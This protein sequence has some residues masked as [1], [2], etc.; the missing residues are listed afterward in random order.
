LL[1]VG[2]VGSVAALA[3]VMIT[4]A[5]AVH[6]LQFQL[7]GDTTTVCGTVPNCSTQVYDWNSLFNADGTNTS[8]INPVGP[9]FTTA[10]FVRDF[11]V[12][13]AS[14]ACSLTDTTSKTFCTGDSTTYAT[15]SKD[16]LNITPGWQCKHDNNVNSKI[17]I[18][19][20]YSAAYTDPASGDKILYFGLDKN[21]DNGNN[22]VGFWFLQGSAN[23]VAASGEKGWTG[24]HQDG[25]VLVVSE[26]TSGGGVSS[27][28]AY[29][30]AGGAS[31]CIDSNDNPNAKTGGCNGQAIENGGDCKEAGTKDAICATTNSGTLAFNG[32]IT[33]KWLTSDATLGVGHTVVPPDFFEGGVNLTKVFNKAGGTVPQ[34]FNTFIGD[35]RSSQSLT[36][37][38]FDYTRGV[39]GECKTTLATQAGAT[40]NGGSA[41][42]SSIGT[43]KVSSG[44]DTATLTVTGTK[45]WGG[46]LTWH[47]CGPVLTDG[48]ESTKGVQVTSRTVSNESAASAFVSGTAQLTSVGR[49]CWTAH[50]Q[51]NAES[52]AAGVKAAD[53]NGANECFTVAPVTPTLTTSASCSASPCVLGSTLSDKAFLKGTAKQPGTN[54]GNSNYPSINATNG[55]PAD[56]SISWVLYSPKSG[57]CSVTKP[58][59]PSSVIVSGDN[60]TTGYGPTSYTTQ[61]SDG[62]GTY[63]FV[64]SYPGDGAGSNTNAAT[65]TS[66][67]DTSGTETVIVEGTS[68]ISSAQRWLPNDRVVV[69]GQANLNGG[70]TVTLYPGGKCEGTPITGQSY[71]TTF[72]EATSPQVFNTS[73]T[74]FFVGTKPDGSAGG[75]AG[76]YSWKVHYK[77]NNLQSPT[78][79]CEKSNVSITN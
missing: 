68:S 20:A 78:D 44:S 71:T 3:A 29:R 34:C 40:A 53:D 54:G 39:L 59:S 17:D 9:G 11:G 32:N 7:D 66:C 42:P 50:F 36:A 70:L 1:L 60:T 10:S 23:C 67:P 43:G 35:T 38:L 49:Y 73:N 5:L 21:K 47:L 19:N 26:F 28:A 41:S 24:N 16:T 58:T 62:I 22:D 65:S 18:M 27:I 8:L 52:E 45:V 55:A 13:T 63:T 31:G 33:T 76:E 64:A 79:I 57:G 15:G 56:H 2:L 6:D 74:S 4:N 37:T 51:P 48:C 25:D 14:G 75:A 12:K 30:W 61:I 46:T 77:D 72:S 69:T